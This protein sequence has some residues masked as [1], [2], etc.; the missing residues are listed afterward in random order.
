[1]APS[2][3]LPGEAGVG[4]CS[5]TLS[6]SPHTGIPEVGAMLQQ[7]VPCQEVRQT[8]P[9][10]GEV[11]G[12][13]TLQLHFGIPG[14]SRGCGVEAKLHGRKRPERTPPGTCCGTGSRVGAVGA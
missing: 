10:A 9:G 2:T 12:K 5:C 14:T 4:G 3:P 6:P 11:P 13:W 8:W 7:H 1:M